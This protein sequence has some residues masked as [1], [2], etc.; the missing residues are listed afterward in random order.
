MRGHILVVDDNERLASVLATNFHLLGYQ[1][2]VAHDG[3][4]AEASIQ[5]EP[6]DLVILDVM[7]P[8]KNGFAVCRDLKMDP[9]LGRIPVV[10][11]TAKDRCEDVFWGHDSGADAYVTKPYDQRKLEMLVTQLL[12]EA[13]DG[14]RTV[15]WTGLPTALRVRK[16]QQA[17]VEAGGATALL[18]VH[19]AEKPAE[20]FQMKYG[21]EQYQH[22]FSELS[23]LL[24][25]ATKTTTSAGVVGVE[26]EDTC[27]VLLH[28][29]EVQ[30]FLDAAQRAVAEL[31]SGAYNQKDR[32][33]G[34]IHF[35]D[36]KT[37]QRE[38]IPL[39]TVETRLLDAEAMHMAVPQAAAS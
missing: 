11:L 26:G 32:E 21:R 19:L 4:Q 36:P 33:A 18:E 34:C 15:S 12:S 39:M 1:V 23:W 35:T 38:E 17:R 5:T 25:E 20:I 37:K 6:P 3:L 27:L 10:L 28:P 2:S 9:V 8:G 30:G 24:N 16:E 22:L 31:L 29:R 13:Q 7:M 14:H